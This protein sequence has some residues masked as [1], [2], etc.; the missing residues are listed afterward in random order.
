MFRQRR[1]GLNMIMAA[2]LNIYSNYIEGRI[3]E[4]GNCD[5]L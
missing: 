5:I 2:Y 4:K 1:L 3:V